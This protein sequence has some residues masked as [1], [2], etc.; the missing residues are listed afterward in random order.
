MK[1]DGR[2]AL[3][4]FIFAIICFLGFS[5]FNAKS[6]ALK[7]DADDISNID[8]NKLR[9][10][11]HVKMEADKCVGYYMS[12][13]RSPTLP[14]ESR[15]YLVLRFNKK[16]GKYDRLI[17]VKVNSDDFE[18]WEKLVE[19]TRN[20]NENTTP[21]H[22]DGY[23]TDMNPKQV[24]TYLSTL[25]K[26]GFSTNYITN[27]SIVVINKKQINRNKFFLLGGGIFFI[28]IGLLYLNWIY[29]P[30]NKDFIP[31]PDTEL[32]TEC[33]DVELSDEELTEK[34]NKDEEQNAEEKNDEE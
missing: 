13:K 23:V 27:Y 5:N 8:I 7:K 10:N 19:D 29:H 22:I 14:D 32:K 11:M 31:Q 2:L 15:N 33:Y 24:N 18:Q 12:S 3:A 9:P 17:D 25:V 16:I 21:I 28:I 4:F 30:F 6:A 34:E 20:N 26:S 1:P